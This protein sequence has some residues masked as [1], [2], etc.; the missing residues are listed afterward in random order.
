MQ[1]WFRKHLHGEILPLP[2]DLQNGDVVG[3]FLYMGGSFVT[4]PKPPDSTWV[5]LPIANMAGAVSMQQGACKTGDVTTEYA[6]A[7]VYGSSTETG[8]T[9]LSM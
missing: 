6:C 8:P 1:C 3:A 4:P 5:E 2:A 9:T 7:H